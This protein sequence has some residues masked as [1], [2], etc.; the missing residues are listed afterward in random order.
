MKHV[1]DTLRDKVVLVTGAFSGI[2]RAT[3]ELLMKHRAR[4]VAVGRKEEQSIPSYAGHYLPIERAIN[5]EYDAFEVVEFALDK[6]K[7]IDAVINLAGTVLI[8]PV[9]EMTEA[10]YKRMMQDNYFSAVNVT[11]AALPEML[12]QKAG[13]I[14]FT[15]CTTSK[16]K[17]TGLAGFRASA[18]ALQT[19]AEE[20]TRELKDSTIQVKNV[21][22]EPVDS[23]FWQRYAEEIDTSRF[24]TCVQAAEDIIGELQGESSASTTPQGEP[25]RL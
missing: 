10:E 14:V 20:L 12:K 22:F 2:G 9:H 7:R 24:Q 17:M 19:F 15:P 25:V 11:R 13:T 21:A 6:Y 16:L 5:S 4:V 1:T 8:K 23:S 3:T 18:F